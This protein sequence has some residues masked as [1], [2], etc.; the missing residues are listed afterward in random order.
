MSCLGSQLAFGDARP[1]SLYYGTSGKHYSLSCY[2]I[3]VAGLYLTQ[4][5]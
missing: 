1:H 3:I 4:A 2:R 5:Y